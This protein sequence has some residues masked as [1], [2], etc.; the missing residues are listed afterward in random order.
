M[1]PTAPVPAAPMVLRT[2]LAWQPRLGELRQGCLGHVGREQGGCMGGRDG[3]EEGRG[4]SP[5]H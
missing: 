1:F 4:M 5:G 2:C 3:D